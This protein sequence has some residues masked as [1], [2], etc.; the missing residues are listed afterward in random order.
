MKPSRDDIEEAIETADVRS[1]DRKPT[2]GVLIE[3]R[4]LQVLATAA[5]W[6]LEVV[7]PDNPPL[8]EDAP[9]RRAP[10]RRKR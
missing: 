7:D 2:D 9:P 4:E 10:R 6:A 5:R 3:V 8:L 1:E